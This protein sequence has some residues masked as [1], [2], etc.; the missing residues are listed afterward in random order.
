LQSRGASALFKFGSDAFWT[1]EGW[2]FIPS[3]GKPLVCSL[4]G[5]RILR[6]CSK[7][8]LYREGAIIW[9]AFGRR[10]VGPSLPQAVEHLWYQ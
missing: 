5:K 1:A 10:A 2:Q 3:S 8:D 4:K 9:D 7:K 6:N